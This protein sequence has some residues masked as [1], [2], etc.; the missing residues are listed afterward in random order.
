MAEDFYQFKNITAAFVRAYSVY[1]ALNSN[2]F[3]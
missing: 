3:K 2:Y 1:T